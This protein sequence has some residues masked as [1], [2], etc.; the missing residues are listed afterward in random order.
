MPKGEVPNETITITVNGKKY[1][2]TIG[3]DVEHWHTLAY[4]FRDRGKRSFGWEPVPMYRIRQ[5]CGISAGC[6]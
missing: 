2:L 1:G 6:R 3:N 4:S 5:D